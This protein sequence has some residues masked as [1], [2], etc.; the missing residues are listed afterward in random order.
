MGDDTQI[1]VEGKG[2]IKLDHG[3]LKNVVYVPFL[4]ENLVYVY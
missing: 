4:V 2:S 1:Q 3:V